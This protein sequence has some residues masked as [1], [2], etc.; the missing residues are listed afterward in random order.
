MDSGTLNRHRRT[1]TRKRG[2]FL[3]LA[4]A[5]AAATPLAAQDAD[6]LERAAA[7]RAKGA[8][9]AP[10][11]VFE[12]ADFQCPYC[13]RFSLDVFPRLDS[14]Y[15]RSGKVQWV[16][17]NLPLTSIHP[18]AWVAAEAALCAGAVAD[19]FW[20]FHDRLFA[21]QDRWANAEDPHP[22]FLAYAREAGIPAEPFE[23]CILG[24]RVASL[25]LEDVVFSAAARVSGTPTFV[26]DRETVVVGLKSFE[27]WS[28]LL[29]EAIQ[30]KAGAERR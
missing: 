16:F 26:I 23:A 3:A 25:L 24:D 6:V 19:G 22:V 27:E 8:H 9:D 5:I 12:I 10:I 17:V 11:L 4:I 13:A 18:R 30:R 28:A 1:R 21:E 14:A 20:D 15:V 7:S 2:V 29:D